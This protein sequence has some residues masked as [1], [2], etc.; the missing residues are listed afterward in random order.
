[1]SWLQHR[2]AQAVWFW[3]AAAVGIAAKASHP[4]LQELKPLLQTL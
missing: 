2:F 1:L 3:S 4:L